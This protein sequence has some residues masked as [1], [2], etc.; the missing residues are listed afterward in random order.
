MCF[1][2]NKNYRD[3]PADWNICDVETNLV[4]V[5]QNDVTLSEHSFTPAEYDYEID[6]IKKV[7]DAT[8]ER[9]LANPNAYSYDALEMY[10]EVT[11]VLECG[12]EQ[13]ATTIKKVSAEK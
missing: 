12:E 10:I 4:S 9:F 1:D 3:E 6:I 5:Y 11:E 8:R 13:E 7:L 2:A